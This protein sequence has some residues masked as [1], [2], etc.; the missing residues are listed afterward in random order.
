MSMPSTFGNPNY[1]K[2]F[3][4]FRIVDESGHEPLRQAI[5]VA[6][7]LRYASESIVKA[8][9]GDLKPETRAQ[10]TLALARCKPDEFQAWIKIAEF[11]YSKPKHIEVSGHLTYEKLLDGSWRDEINEGDRIIPKIAESAK[12]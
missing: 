7:E 2:K 5:S 11:I 6:L 9:D 3:D 10:L 1:R 8:L 12:E 4:A